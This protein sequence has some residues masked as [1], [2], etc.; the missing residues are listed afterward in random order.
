MHYQ[1][2]R[3]ED[4]LVIIAV[5]ISAICAMNEKEGK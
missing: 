2:A 1:K 3:K 4:L 5:E